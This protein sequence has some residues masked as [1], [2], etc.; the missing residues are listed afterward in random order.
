MSDNTNNFFD[1][2]DKTRDIDSA[3]GY[4]APQ[5]QAP[6]KAEPTV[7][8]NYQA[9]KQYD[10]VGYTAAQQSTPVAPQQPQQNYASAAPVQPQKYSVPVTSAPQVT[11]NKKPKKDKGGF[12]KDFVAVMLVVSIL[13]SSA[14][15]FAGAAI[16]M[17]IKDKPQENEKKPVVSDSGALVINTVDID[18]QTA[19]KLSDKP[20]SQITDEVADTVVEITTETMTTS[21]FYG[22]YIAQGAGSGVIISEDGYILTNNHVIEGA[23]SITVTLRDQTTY[24]AELIGT[25][26]DM[27]IA[28][29]KIDGSGLKTAILGDSSKLKVGDKA[30]A[31]GNPLGQL[32]GTVTDGIISALDREVISEGKT[33]T[34]LQTD[35]AINPGNSGGGLFDGQGVLIGI[36]VAKHTGSEIEGLGFAVPINNVKEILDDLKQYG[37]V[38]GRVS[39]GVELMDIS[40]GLYAFYYFGASEKGC[41]VYSVTAG[42]SA[43]D[44]GLK[45]GD[46]IIKVDGTKISTASDVET[47]IDGKEVGDKIEIVVDRDGKEKTFEVELE[48]YIPEDVRNNR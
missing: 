34:L 26:A 35:T 42:S 14:V 13:L 44:A 25:D 28:L 10:S 12:S 40:N 24:K 32:G 18:E 31:I 45:D 9:P 22:Q 16:Y 5:Y 2:F 4:P 29:I 3:Q 1:G 23:S 38:R 39:L 30:V 47:A 37:Y 8:Y 19:Q 20:T 48:E 46:R 17:G 7:A 15:G 6:K 21:M 36:V 43:H 33:M 41:Y 11:N 27:D